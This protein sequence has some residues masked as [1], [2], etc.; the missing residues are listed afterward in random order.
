MLR[1]ESVFHLVRSYL[2]QLQVRVRR[3]QEICLKLRE[4][5]FCLL[6]WRW[7]RLDQQ[8]RGALHNFLHRLLAALLQVHDTGVVLLY[9]I[10]YFKI[11]ATGTS[12]CRFGSNKALADLNSDGGS[13]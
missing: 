5:Y 12:P 9:I 11:R 2:V 7:N 10:H 6:V 1:P 13:R 4:V 8:I 3:L